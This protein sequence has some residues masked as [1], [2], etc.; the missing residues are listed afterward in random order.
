MASTKSV[1]PLPIQKRTA[2][3]MYRCPPQKFISYN[4]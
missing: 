2:S 4:Y 1:K 3:T